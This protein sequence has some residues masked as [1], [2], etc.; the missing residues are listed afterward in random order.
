MI[1]ALNLATTR[2]PLG[3]SGRMIVGGDFPQNG[4]RRSKDLVWGNYHVRLQIPL[5][6]LCKQGLPKFVLET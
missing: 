5:W 1:C 2:G 4:K 6:L 3:S